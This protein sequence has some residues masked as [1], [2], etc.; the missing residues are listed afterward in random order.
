MRLRR[1][2]LRPDSE[3]V[4]WQLAKHLLTRGRT[5]RP[6]S[7]NPFLPGQ[8]QTHREPFRTLCALHVER[9]TTAPPEVISTSKMAMS[10]STSVGRGR[11][12]GVEGKR[13]RW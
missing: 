7:L 8:R 12:M 5:F 9:Y 13:S 3:S 4:P 11:T 1:W 10:T 6:G 2:S